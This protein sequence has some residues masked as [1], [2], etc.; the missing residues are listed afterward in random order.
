LDEVLSSLDR[1]AVALVVGLIQDHLKSGGIAVVS[2][3][4]ELSLSAGSFQR[5]ELAS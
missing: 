1:N 2:T 5:L 4:Q 3:H